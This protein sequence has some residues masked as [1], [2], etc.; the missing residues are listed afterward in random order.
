MRIVRHTRTHVRL[1]NVIESRIKNPFSPCW[2][3]VHTQIYFFFFKATYLA[4]ITWAKNIKRQLRLEM[5]SSG[6]LLF[7]FYFREMHRPLKNVAYQRGRAE[8]IIII[9]W[10]NLNG[11]L[12][13]CNGA[14]C[15]KEKLLSESDGIERNSSNSK[16]V[17]ITTLSW[18]FKQMESQR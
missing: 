5:G 16:N 18:H 3:R 15:H 12:I 7:F 14:Q 4:K 1:P 11:S 2:Q 13:K 6:D 10:I 8:K 9:Y 17:L